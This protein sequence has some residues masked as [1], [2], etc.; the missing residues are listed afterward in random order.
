MEGDDL[1]FVFLRA[2]AVNS[3]LVQVGPELGGIR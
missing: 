2:E 3:A 1:G